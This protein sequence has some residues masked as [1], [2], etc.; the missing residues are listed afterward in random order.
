MI[1]YIFLLITFLLK[2]KIFIKGKNIQEGEYPKEINH[3]I[4]QNDTWNVSV[5][6]YE[7]YINITDY[8]L[9]EEN[10]FEL[11]CDW[12]IFDKVDI[13]ALITNESI[14]KIED[15]T[16]KPDMDKDYYDMSKDSIKID[17]VTKDYYLFLPFKKTSINQT[18][19]II[20]IIPKFNIS[21]VDI[22]YSLS[23]R[24]SYQLKFLILHLLNASS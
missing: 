17:S 4:L 22:N 15:Q 2:S 8:E 13:Y 19:L 3:G 18:Y 10:I 11:Y 14:D 5:N 23:K 20:L 6:E 16:I 1:H 21:S 7:Y 9:N 24:I 12:F